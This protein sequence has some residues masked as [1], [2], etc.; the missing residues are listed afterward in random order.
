MYSKVLMVT[1]TL[2]YISNTMRS[3][4]QALHTDLPQASI[5]IVPIVYNYTERDC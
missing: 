5:H 3:N 4:V 1:A 2:Q